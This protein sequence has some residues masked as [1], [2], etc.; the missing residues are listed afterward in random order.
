MGGGSTSTD[1][2]PLKLDL[3][4]LAVPAPMRIE[5]LI[6]TRPAAPPSFAEAPAAP[7][8]PPPVLVPAAPVDNAALAAALHGHL[9]LDDV[10]DR[11]DG[12]ADGRRELEHDDRLLVGRRASGRP[13]ERQHVL[14]PH[15]RH[16]V[17]A[18][19]QHLAA[20]DRLDP[21]RLDAL[22]AR[23][24]RERH[25]ALRVARAEDEE[26]LA[27]RRRRLR[28]LRRGRRAPRADLHVGRRGDQ[29]GR[30]SC[31]ERV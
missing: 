19:L 26:R 23:N 6:P 25:G 31:R 12:E 28:L 3:P 7:A 11:V 22:D 20:T 14:E 24:Q 9:G 30:A 21:A 16:D 13:V 29:I 15:D 4:L 10:D 27:V 5:D 17:A 1:E 18:V 2:L 8:M